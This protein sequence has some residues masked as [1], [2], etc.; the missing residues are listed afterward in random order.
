LPPATESYPTKVSTSTSALISTTLPTHVS[1]VS[2]TSQPSPSSPTASSQ[3]SPSYSPP[4]TSLTSPDSPFTMSSPITSSLAP[5]NSSSSPFVSPTVDDVST[6]PTSE[7][8][9]VPTH[10]MITK[11]R[12]G[13]RM[14]KPFP[15]YKLYYS[16]RHPLLALHTQA[17]LADLPPTPSRFSQ[18]AKSP[19][20][21]KVM[22][23]EFTALQANHT[24]TLCPWPSN[25]NIITNKWVFK[26]K[27]NVDGTLDRFKAR[28]VAKGFQQQDEIDYH[29][30]FSPVVKPSTI[31]AIHAVVVHYH[32][33]T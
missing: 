18:A 11:L 14:S 19:N 21:Q 15:N 17:S 30:T 2:A 29:D 28:L 6:P 25:K 1:P 3:P 32:W 16:T 7:P 27:Q 5:E 23:E 8:P 33:P 10:P 22:Q 4:T 12:D 31:W 24:W 20:W 13:T 9:V 26:V